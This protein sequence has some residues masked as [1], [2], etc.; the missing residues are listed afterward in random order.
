MRAGWEKEA[1]ASPARGSS[2][3]QQL[4]D[5]N[6]AVGWQPVGPLEAG[7]HV[8][9]I[10][11]VE[12][13]HLPLTLA[14]AIGADPT[15]I[16]AVLDDLQ[17]RGLINRQPD[18]ADRRARLVSLTREGRRLR[19]S[20]QAAI[21]RGE[22]RL[23]AILEPTDRT[24]FLNAMQQLWATPALEVLRGEASASFQ[25]GRSEAGPGQGRAAGGVVARG[26]LP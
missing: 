15:R 3:L 10:H 1:G 7:V 9:Q 19:D 4:A 12:G 14:D 21:Q 26:R 22:E 24:G 18:P 11:D 23:L 6:V 5:L 17:A 13:L 8:G 20:A 2:E 25:A 16:I